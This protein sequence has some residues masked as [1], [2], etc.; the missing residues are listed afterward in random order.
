VTPTPPAVMAASPLAPSVEFGSGAYRAIDVTEQP[1]LVRQ[2]G[3][4]YTPEAMRAGIQGEVLLD[5]VV[6]PDGSVGDVR[7][8]KSL[9]RQ[10]GLDDEA[11]KTVK[12][13]VFKPGTLDGKA[14]PVVMQAIMVFRLRD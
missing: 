6:A 7:I 12:Q 13:W 5:V 14:V 8:A 4:R 10:F 9:D 3:A 11:I 2:V 1:T